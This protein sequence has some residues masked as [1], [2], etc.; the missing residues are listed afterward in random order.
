MRLLPNSCG[1][2][3]SVIDGG[4]DVFLLLRAK[5]NQ[6]APSIRAKPK[7]PPVTPPTTPPT[8]AAELP[9]WS[10]LAGEEGTVLGRGAEDTNSNTAIW[11]EDQAGA[12]AAGSEML[13]EDVVVELGAEEG[14]AD[15]FESTFVSSP[16]I[17]QTLCPP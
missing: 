3:P 16:L 15:G 12:N 6:Q 1:N 17:I 11:P 9:F 5:K 2:F 4:W 8:F 7:S 10:D 14:A 13:G